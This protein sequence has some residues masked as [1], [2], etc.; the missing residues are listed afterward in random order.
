M[1]AAVSRP[2]STTTTREMVGKSRTTKEW[3][4]VKDLYVDPSYQRPLDEVRVAKMV[5]NFDPDALGFP[6]VAELPQHRG[7][8]KYAIIDGNHRINTVIKALGPDQLVECEV[9]RDV[10]IERAAQLFLLRNQSARPN[11]LSRFLA[12]LRSGEPEATEVAKIVMKEGLRI[13]VGRGNGTIQAVNALLRIY[14]G[15][16][17]KVG[18]KTYPLALS[19]VLVMVTE[20]WGNG[21]DSYNGDILHGLGLFLLRNGDE[22]KVEDLVRKLKQYP[23]GPLNLLGAAR[24]WKTSSGTT[25]P[26]AVSTVIANLYNRSKRKGQL[27]AWSDPVEKEKE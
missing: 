19:R 7:P 21:P 12:A 15:N 22:V 4:P 2:R 3:L 17:T 16:R 1:P 6:F 27:L 26:V 5:E 8:G 9:I 24:G 20:A 13:A 10:T 11:T 23:G 18:T 25:T 14:R